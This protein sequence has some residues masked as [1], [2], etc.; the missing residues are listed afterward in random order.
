MTKKNDYIDVEYTEDNDGVKRL[1]PAKKQKKEEAEAIA[2]YDSTYDT[3]MGIA[4]VAGGIATI[5]A[6][7]AH[8]IRP[9]D[10]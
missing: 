7:I 10:R 8:H 5:A 1:P 6:A 4:T 9:S 2:P 3:L